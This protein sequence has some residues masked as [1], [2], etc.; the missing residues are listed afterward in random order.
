MDHGHS[1]GIQEVDLSTAHSHIVTGR[2]PTA[3]L[4][5]LE[6]EGVRSGHRE[7]V[8]LV[9]HHESRGV[10][11]VGAHFESPRAAMSIGAGTIFCKRGHALHGRGGKDCTVT[12]VIAVFQKVDHEPVVVMSVTSPLREGTGK[13]T[14][15]SAGTV[16]QFHPNDF[17]ISRRVEVVG[18]QELR[19]AEAG[20]VRRQHFDASIHRQDGNCDHQNTPSERYK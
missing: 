17:A 7:R 14:G 1:T 6:A 3:S 13:V 5:H 18:R 20:V 4:A 11:G 15:D 10:V 9:L 19:R 12:A 8:F 16:F 2:C